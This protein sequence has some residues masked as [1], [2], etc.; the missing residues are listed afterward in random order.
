MKRRIEFLARRRDFITLLGGAAASSAAWPLAARAQQSVR[1]AKIGHLESGFP[2]SSPNLLAAFRQGLR[3]LGYVEGQNL[4]IERRY[5]EGREERLPQLAEELVQFGVDVIF[6]IGPPQ[7]LAAAKAT[8]RIPIVFVGGGDPVAMGLVRS[9]AQPGGNLTGLTF[10]TVELASK[11]IQLL[12]DAVPIAKRVAVLWNP[13]NVINKL[14]LEKATATAETL[15]LTPLPIETRVLEDI[16]GAFVAMTRQR[17]DAAL[18]LSSPLTFP[19]RP[20]I[21]ESALRARMPTLGALREYA[22]AG[23]LMSYGPS[24]ADHCRRA[25]TYVDQILKG[26]KPADLPVQLPTTFELVINLKTAS[27]LGLEVPPTLLARADEVIE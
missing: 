1:I 6:A 22:E 2:S 5:G 4:F 16:E 13:T 8:N 26:A 11:R 14:E 10:V 25:A 3:E 18:V 24:Y 23:V 9:F 12:K 21:V 7:A 27:A 19:N 20:R 15:G 17:A